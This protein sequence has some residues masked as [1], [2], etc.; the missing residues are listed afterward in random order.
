VELQS[1]T[2]DQA[3]LKTLEVVLAHERKRADWV[4]AEDVDL[5]F[6]SDR[7]QKLLKDSKDGQENRVNRRQL[8]V[9]VF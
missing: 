3:L 4:A 2:Q 7:W 1:T 9:C 8:E 5:S 6:V